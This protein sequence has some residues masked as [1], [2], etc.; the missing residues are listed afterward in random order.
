MVAIDVEVPDGAEGLDGGADAGPNDDDDGF[1]LI[2]SIQMIKLENSKIL[3]FPL[4]IITIPFLG[5]WLLFGFEGGFVLP[6]G[7]DVSGGTLV[8]GLADFIKIGD[9][10][11]GLGFGFD[12][13]SF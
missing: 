1:D 2:I 3:F 11:V 4:K 6:A 8:D 5:F 9:G 12:G 13:F 10:G 7:E